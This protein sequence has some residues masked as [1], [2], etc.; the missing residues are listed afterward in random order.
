M[1]NRVELILYLTK[2]GFEI[3]ES[4]GERDERWRLNLSN[5]NYNPSKYSY[6]AYDWSIFIYKNTNEVTIWKPRGFYSLGDDFRGKIKNIHQ[7]EVILETLE[8]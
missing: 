8:I 3:D 5:K 1:D 2:K 6:D 7:L 4:Y